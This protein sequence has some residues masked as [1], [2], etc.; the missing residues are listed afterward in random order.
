[1]Y[2][3]PPPQREIIAKWSPSQRFWLQSWFE[4]LHEFSASVFRV[5][6]I[7]LS[8]VAAE[9]VDVVGLWK[10]GSVTSAAADDVRKELLHIVRDDPLLPTEWPRERTS[11]LSALGSGLTADSDVSLLV[12]CAT[13]LCRE[14][15]VS[16]YRARLIEVLRSLVNDGGTPQLPRFALS[17]SV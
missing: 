15:F 3:F 11:F 16:A 10:G 7:P 12:W 5:R 14:R 4:L 8:A 6:P 2:R 13:Q 9:L 1:V 17:Q